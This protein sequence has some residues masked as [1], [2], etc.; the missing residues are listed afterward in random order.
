MTT[1]AP[2][3]LLLLAR[4]KG[5]SID[6]AYDGWARFT[7]DVSYSM[8][9]TVTE[10]IALENDSPLPDH[11]ARTQRTR[12]E[13]APRVALMIL[14]TNERVN[15]NRN[16]CRNEATPQQNSKQRKTQSSKKENEKKRKKQGKTRATNTGI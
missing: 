14:V 10:A 3:L 8:S 7:L 15:G 2:P 11:L 6:P 5:S 13:L 4:A 12:H 9:F 16:H 1:T